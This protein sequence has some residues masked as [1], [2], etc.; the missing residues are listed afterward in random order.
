MPRT[1]YV[2]IHDFM[3]RGMGLTGCELSVYAMIYSFSKNDGEFFG[4]QSYI[5]DWYGISTRT[6]GRALKKLVELG[7]IVKTEKGNYYADKNAVKAAASE[8]SDKLSHRSKSASD[9]TNTAPK[10]DKT[11]D[12]TNNNKKTIT[13]TTTTNSARG[14][15][16][17]RKE[18]GKVIENS[19]YSPQNPKYKPQGYDFDKIVRMTP[20]QYRSLRSLVSDEDLELYLFRM[21]VM[22]SKTVNKWPCYVHSPYRTIRKWIEE[23]FGIKGD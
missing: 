10:P 1:S 17:E 5:A 7:L 4:S 6:V 20:E 21:S 14:A 18:E 19:A 9:A 22:M 11:A 15:S 23:D 2:E 8:M 3:V 12:N 13:S 16:E